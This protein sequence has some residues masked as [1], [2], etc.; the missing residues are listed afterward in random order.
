MHALTGG[1]W[2]VQNTSKSVAAACEAQNASTAAACTMWTSDRALGTI[3]GVYMQS[4]SRLSLSSA[5]VEILQPRQPSIEVRALLSDLR[6]PNCL[7]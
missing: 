5:A 2:K 6:Q 4:R 1:L 3:E 7:R